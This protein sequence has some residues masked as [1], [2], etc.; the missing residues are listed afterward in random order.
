MS[1]FLLRDD[2]IRRFSAIPE[3]LQI[4]TYGGRCNRK[5]HVVLDVHGEQELLAAWAGGRHSRAG[6]GTRDRATGRP[7]CGSAATPAGSDRLAA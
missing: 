1:L 7:Q 4:T 2:S 6:T 5:L 3:G